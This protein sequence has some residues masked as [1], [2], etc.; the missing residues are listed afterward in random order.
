MKLDYFNHKYFNNYY[1]ANILSNLSDQ[2][3][4]FLGF[5]SQFF[6]IEPIISLIKPWQKESTF[7]RFIFYIISNTIEDEFY[8][9]AVKQLNIAKKRNSAKY[10]SNGSS[11]IMDITIFHLNNFILRNLKILK[12]MIFMIIIMN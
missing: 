12:K 2:R 6:E 9:N 4:E 10:T 5:I 11:K 7:H 1:Y 8:K 3:W